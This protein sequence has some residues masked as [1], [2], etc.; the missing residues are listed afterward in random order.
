ML[1]RLRQNI[2]ILQKYK[3]EVMIGAFSSDPMDMRNGKDV[4]CLIS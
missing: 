3:V 1:G 4:W 2:T